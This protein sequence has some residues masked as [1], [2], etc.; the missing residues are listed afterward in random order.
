[1]RTCLHTCGPRTGC[2]QLSVPS[3]GCNAALRLWATTL[4]RVKRV[5]RWRVGLS[6]QRLALC[7]WSEREHH[8]KGPAHAHIRPRLTKISLRPTGTSSF[9]TMAYAPGTLR[10]ALFEA[11]RRRG[12]GQGL[13]TGRGRPCVEAGEE[14]GGGC[15]ASASVVGG[16]E[17]KCSG[18]RLGHGKW[19]RPL[20]AA[21]WARAH[22]RRRRLHVQEVHAT[23]QRCHLCAPLQCSWGPC[24]AASSLPCG[25]AT[26]GHHR[27]SLR[28]G[29]RRPAVGWP[30]PGFPARTPTRIACGMCRGATV[31]RL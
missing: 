17:C 5:A 28:T 1:M 9:I 4:V 18:R 19:A 22:M 14:E 21:A 31:L 29:Q 6:T 16:C 27:A 26:L 3:Q 25:S 13:A 23:E 7:A 11:G 8:S 20:S 10:A 24:W 2:T 30:P 12:G 15:R